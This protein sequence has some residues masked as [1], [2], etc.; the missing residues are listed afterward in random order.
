MSLLIGLTLCVPHGGYALSLKE[1]CL[2]YLVFLPVTLPLNI[3]ESRIESFLQKHVLCRM[4]HM[5]GGLVLHCWIAV[6]EYLWRVFRIL[7]KY[8]YG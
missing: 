5:K 7:V 4:C 3:D 8:S 1:E 2:V 6:H